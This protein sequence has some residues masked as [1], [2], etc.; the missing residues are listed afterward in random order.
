MHLTL[1]HATP[2]QTPNHRTCLLSTTSAINQKCLLGRS[3]SSLMMA[4]IAP[5][6]KIFDGALK[7]MKSTSNYS[8]QS[9]VDSLIIAA[10]CQLP[11]PLRR[12]WHIREHLSVDGN[13]I[14]HGC[15]LLISNS[16]RKQVLSELHDSHQGAVRT[17]QR[18][19]L[20]VYWPG[21]DNDIENIVFRCKQCQDHLPSNHKEPILC[22]PTPVRPFQEVA[23]DFCSHGGQYYLILVDFCT[24]W[25]TIV[26]MGLNTTAPRLVATV[27]QSFCRTGIPTS[28]GPMG[29]LNLLRRPSRILY[30]DGDFSIKPQHQ[31]THK[32]MGKSKPL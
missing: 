16:M 13:L 30:A 11:D 10:S 19:H 4:M 7:M 8:A 25:P 22:K 9:S 20:T 28:F 23:A 17:K 1:C 18:A 15:R 14:V 32:V 31:D 26:P 21:I 2:C 29:D 5:T 6:S 27:R 3:E 12:Y 24:D